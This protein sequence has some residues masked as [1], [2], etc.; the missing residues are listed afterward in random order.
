MGYVFTRAVRLHARFFPLARSIINILVNEYVIDEFWQIVH[1]VEGVGAKVQWLWIK[2]RVLVDVNV[3]EFADAQGLQVRVFQHGDIEA[4]ELPQH[5]VQLL[6]RGLLAF[7]SGRLE[8]L[9]WRL[10]CLRRWHCGDVE[11]GKTS[12]E[13]TTN[14]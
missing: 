13:D 8:G 12:S 2:R 5:G 11:E 9:D 3:G 6:V 4:V 14:E 7:A 10:C 1:T